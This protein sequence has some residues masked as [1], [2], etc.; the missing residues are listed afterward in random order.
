MLCSRCHWRERWPLFSVFNLPPARIYLGDAGSLTIGLLISALSDPVVAVAGPGECVSITAG[1]CALDLAAPGHLDRGWPALAQR[2]LD[3]HARPRAHSSLLEKSPGQRVIAALGA[4]VVL[5][6]LGAGGAVLA[7]TCGMGD[8][9]ACL[10]LA[11][12]VGLLTCTNTFGATE[13]RLLLFRLKVALAP[14]PAG[15]AV[16]GRGLRQECH[17]RRQPGLGGRLGRPG[18]RSRGQR[19]QANRAGD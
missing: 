8:P 17:I 10:A 16:R 2:P 13:L 4:A 19:R 14:V 12:C 15:P 5:A 11:F 1:A 18:P 9:A 7:T 3:L 6:T